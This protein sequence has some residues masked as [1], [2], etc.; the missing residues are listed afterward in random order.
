MKSLL[1]THTPTQSSE[2]VK[3]QGFYLKSIIGIFLFILLSMGVQAQNT[4]S[5]II[6]NKSRCDVDIQLQYCSGTLSVSMSC[7]A[8]D[9]AT[10]SIPSEPKIYEGTFD[11]GITLPFNGTFDSVCSTSSENPSPDVC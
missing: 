11:S 9:A 3:I 7:P 4:Y 8:Y 1:N 10:Y 2:I 6:Q 5:L